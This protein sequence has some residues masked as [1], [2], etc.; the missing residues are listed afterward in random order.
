MLRQ[1]WL[2]GRLVYTIVYIVY[3]R[4][5]LIKKYINKNV[6]DDLQAAETLAQATA[7]LE[8]AESSTA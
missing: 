5:F 1:G 8:N 7:A 2:A 6:S 3:N 4:E